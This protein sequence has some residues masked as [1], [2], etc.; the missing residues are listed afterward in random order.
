[1]IAVRLKSEVF[2]LTQGFELHQYQLLQPFSLLLTY[3]VYLLYLISFHTH[4][5]STLSLFL[6]PDQESKH[7]V[8]QTYNQKWLGGLSKYTSCT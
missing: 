1:M 7:Q 3:Y 2:N 8:Q 6:S 5:Y 4:H